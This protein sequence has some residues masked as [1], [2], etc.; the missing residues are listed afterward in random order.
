MFFVFLS[1]RSCK[2]QSHP[3]FSFFSICQ[4]AVLWLCFSVIHSCRHIR[5]V[6]DTNTC[7]VVV[8][9]IQHRQQ[10]LLWLM[11]WCGCLLH[12]YIYWMQE[13]LRCWKSDK[14]LS[15]FLFLWLARSLSLLSYWRLLFGTGARGVSNPE[16]FPV[17]V[18]VLLLY[19]CD[20]FLPLHKS[21]GIFLAPSHICHRLRFTAQN[22]KMLYI[23][24]V[25]FLKGRS[26][27]K[28]KWV[29]WV[30]Y[31][32]WDCSVVQHCV[33]LHMSSSWSSVFSV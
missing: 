27:V 33:H 9:V 29:K 13:R 5:T 25:T 6:V 32:W 20:R 26:A 28:I 18:P 17:E 8:Q 14:S 4:P 11:T 24:L 2:T 31:F 30:V 3:L 23:F 22:S 21:N 12:D 10:Q 16:L 7:S 19:C 15:F 1:L